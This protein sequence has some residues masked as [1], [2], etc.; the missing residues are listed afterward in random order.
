MVFPKFLP[1]MAINSVISV[2]L[3]LG[4]YSVALNCVL[5]NTALNEIAAEAAIKKR[6]KK[7]VVNLL[8]MKNLLINSLSF[9]GQL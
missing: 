2:F 1:T 9:N 6:F 8:R 3:K 5:N 7:G 4:E